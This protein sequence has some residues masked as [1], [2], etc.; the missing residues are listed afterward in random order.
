MDQS[1]DA[2]IKSAEAWLTKPIG[3]DVHSFLDVSN[4]IVAALQ[5]LMHQEGTSKQEV[6]AL[7]GQVKGRQ[8]AIANLELMDWAPVGGGQLAI[9]HRPSVKMGTDLKLQNATHVLTLLSEGEQAK[10]IQAIAAKNRMEWLWFSMESARPPD[11]ERLQELTN[12]F[13]KMT[14]ILQE[15]GKIYLHCSAGIHRTGMISYAFL[16]FLDNDADQAL[17]LLKALRTKTS[18]EVG[19]E[20]IA[21]GEE[22]FKTLQNL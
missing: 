21:W 18:E 5:H 9:G 6:G 20:R 2:I 11:E 10:S 14:T 1:L 12:L 7:I 3:K 17:A 8:K 19:L 4:E 15:G 16:R 13:K 22:V